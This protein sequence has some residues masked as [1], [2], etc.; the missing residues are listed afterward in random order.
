MALAFFDLGRQQGVQIS[1]VAE[2]LLNGLVGKLLKLGRN[3]RCPLAVC[4]S[5][6]S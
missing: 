3:G 1:Y 2:S 6:E 4:N 5:D